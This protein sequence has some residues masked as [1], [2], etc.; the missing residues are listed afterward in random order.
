MLQQTQKTWQTSKEQADISQKWLIRNKTM[1]QKDIISESDLD[2]TRSAY[3]SHRYQVENL[4]KEYT[5]LCMDISDTENKIKQLAIEKY[6]KENEMKLNLFSAY[7]DL[8]DNLKV[9]EQTYVF[10]APF[11][12]KVE[13]MKFWTENEFVQNGEEVFS[14]VPLQKD[15]IG[16]VLLPASGAG[17]VE[18]G[19][20][21][22]IKLDNYPYIEFGSIEGKVKSISLVT[23]EQYTETTN[24][25]TYLVSVSL[26]KGMM[27]NYGGQLGF[28][29]EIKG[30]A[31][32]IVKKRRLIERLF[33]NLKYRIK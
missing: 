18:N 22:I 3:L 5:S 16:Q 33:D 21:V 19:N 14:I 13:F 32:I 15:I 10:K 23:K 17:K 27:T 9:W 24:I 20:E 7:Y 6:E 12:G 28:K 29:Y 11:A 8:A 26:P 2:Q 31:E 1:N 4:E 30:T 25:E